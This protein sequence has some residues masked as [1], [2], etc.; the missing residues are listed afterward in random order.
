M[1]ILST[2]FAH[3]KRCND[4][5][6]SIRKGKFHAVCSVLSDVHGANPTQHISGQEPKV[7]ARASCVRVCV[8]PPISNIL[9]RKFKSG[10]GN[11]N[12]HAV[13]RANSKNSTTG[14]REKKYHEREEEKSSVHHQ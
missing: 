7:I 5:F 6:R 4:I 9:L 3:L 13:L 11:P 12:C 2:P 10:R 1:C 14:S 8:R